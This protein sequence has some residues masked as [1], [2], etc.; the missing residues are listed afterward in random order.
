MKIKEGKFTF[1]LSNSTLQQAKLKR[2]PLSHICRDAINKALADSE[3]F[4]ENV[5]PLHSKKRS[6]QLWNMISKFFVRTLPLENWEEIKKSSFKLEMFRQ[7]SIQKC[8]NEMLGY[9]GEFIQGG[10][11]SEEILEI[12]LASNDFK[13]SHED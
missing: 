13:E 10:E 7:F 9:F 8:P 12:Y 6:A 11:Y 5:A 4:N 1:R 3:I 2:L